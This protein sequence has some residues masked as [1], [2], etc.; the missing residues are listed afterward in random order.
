[1]LK[2][3]VEILKIASNNSDICNGD[4]DND[5]IISSLDESDTWSGVSYCIKYDI[6]TRPLFVF[7]ANLYDLL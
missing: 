2:N 1:M 5:S 4:D 3:I 6:N 7:E